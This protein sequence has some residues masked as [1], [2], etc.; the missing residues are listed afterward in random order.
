MSEVATV[1]LSLF[2][3]HSEPRDPSG[4]QEI[5]DAPYPDRL[6]GPRPPQHP[7]S[8]PGS[9]PGVRLLREPIERLVRA[10]YQRRWGL[11]LCLYDVTTLYFEAE[12]EDE[13]RKVAY[14]EEHQVDPGLLIDRYGFP[15]RLGCWEGNKAETTTIIPIVKAFQAAHSIE[16]LV[17]VADAR[18]ALSGQPDSTG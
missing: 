12:K 10:C 9:G 17:I 1:S 8:V 11:A 3:Q 14:S 15:L 2:Q 6:T 7:A 5:S 13:L 4:R 18:Y 16:E